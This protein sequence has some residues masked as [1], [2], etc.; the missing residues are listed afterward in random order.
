[1]WR[2]LAP[3]RPNEGWT[4][5]HIT[6]DV[7]RP[8]LRP[9]EMCARTVAEVLSHYE[10]FRTHFRLTD[11]G[12]LQQV[13]QQSCTINAALF[14]EG[15]VPVDI[16][17]STFD[18]FAPPLLRVGLEFDASGVRR[19]HLSWSHLLLDGYSTRL[20]CGHLEAAMSGGATSTRPVVQPVDRAD[21]ETS[22]EGVAYNRRSLRHWRSNL[23][24]FPA[25]YNHVSDEEC[26]FFLGRLDASQMVDAA[27]RAAA[28]LHV[29]VPTVLVAAVAQTLGETIGME[30]LPFL[31]RTG[32][33]AGR[34]ALAVSQM[35][36]DA[37]A[38]FDLVRGDDDVRAS[39]PSLHERLLL[40]QMFG[41]YH[42]ADL[43]ALLES[44]MPGG[45]APDRRVL[46]NCRD[47]VPHGVAPAVTD[48]S[49]FEWIGER[50]FD[51]VLCYVDI[52]AEDGVF[53]FMLD[54]RFISRRQFENALPT[55][56]GLPASWRAISQ[57]SS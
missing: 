25:R 57:S 13:V 18:I 55:L 39:L 43:E 21:W 3:H 20:V 22:P 17:T 52:Y 29:S 28:A 24:Q 8:E 36:E 9:M 30:K 12:R 33:R 1:M 48:E 32:N 10:T 42:P 37:P 41:A 11:E 35:A 45:V 5:S 54:A 14:P 26:G 47:K 56:T 23:P 34:H 16:R 7:N 19:V 53:I 44:V 27:A 2:A 50:K 51:P 15:D 4:N 6:F 49:R 38:V 46:V 40:A 31:L